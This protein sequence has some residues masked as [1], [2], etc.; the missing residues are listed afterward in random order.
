MAGWE[1]HVFHGNIKTKSSSNQGFSTARFEL[2]KASF[3]AYFQPAALALEG[4][5]FGGFGG[6]SLMSFGWSLGCRRFFQGDGRPIGAAMAI[7][8]SADY[9]IQLGGTWRDCKAAH[10]HFCRGRKHLQLCDLHLCTPKDLM[11]AA[12]VIF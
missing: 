4:S 8:L 6:W 7:S 11:A 5:A 2:V 9:V 1:I 10:F 3:I 12:H